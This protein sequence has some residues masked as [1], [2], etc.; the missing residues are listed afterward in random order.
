[1]KS[2]KQQLTYPGTTV[3]AVAV[4]LADPAFR[5]A[6]CDAQRVLRKSVS[7][8]GNRVRIEQ[9]QAADRLPSFAK[10]LVGDQI[11]IVRDETW[12]STSSGTLAVTIPGKPGEMT[13]TAALAQVGDDVVETVELD[14]KVG[15]MNEGLV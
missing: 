7:I 10:K 9:V 4:M 15:R 1:M 12:T 11:T 6:V 13:G 3:E 8:D 5:E 14:I 2:T